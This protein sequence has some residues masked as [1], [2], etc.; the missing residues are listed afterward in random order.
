MT[1]KLDQGAIEFFTWPL[2]AF[3]ED[4]QPTTIVSA[5]ITFTTGGGLITKSAP[6]VDG[7]FRVLIAGPMAPAQ[8]DAVVLPLGRTTYKLTVVDVVERLV[9]PEGVIRVS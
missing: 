5:K 1:D 7:K 8:D 2:A 6:V 3:D 4:G 9:S